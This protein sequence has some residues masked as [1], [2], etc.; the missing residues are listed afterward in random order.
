MNANINKYHSNLSK[1][2]IR[3]T[4]FY[5][6]ESMRWL[7]VHDDMAN[8]FHIIIWCSFLILSDRTYIE[9]MMEFLSTFV[10]DD[11]TEILTL[12]LQGQAHRLTYKRLDYIMSIGHN[13][14]THSR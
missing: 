9:P 10:R 12:R 7:R 13:I 3:Q 2:E 4:K 5:H 6:K 14:N 11:E 1:R 8:L